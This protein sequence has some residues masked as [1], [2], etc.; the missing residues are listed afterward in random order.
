[1]DRENQVRVRAA[2]THKDVVREQYSSAKGG[3][4]TL[5]GWL[6]G[7]EPM[8]DAFFRR[9]WIDV[10]RARRILD[11]GCGLGR[12]LRRALRYAPEDSQLVAL[13]L[14]VAMLQR[15]RTRV[16]DRRV[17]Y[18]AGDVTRLPFR[19]GSF[20]CVICAWVLEHLPEP[21]VGLK[22]LGRVLASSGKL[23]VLVTEATLPGR[24]SGWLWRC[25]PQKRQD[26]LARCEASGL[27]CTRELW[28]TPLHRLLH[29]GGIC[30]ELQHAHD[31][32]SQ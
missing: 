28:W 13:D 25:F 18:V 14:S 5:T 2:D 26:F 9:G 17:R 7:H 29:L 31:G 19:S 1:M 24:V 32:L 22:E 27:R 8:A 23:Y 3:L 30:L 20:D 16:E 12:F 15:T 4:L 6:S 21:G 10:R 11:V